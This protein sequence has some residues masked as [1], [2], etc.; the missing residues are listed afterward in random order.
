MVELAPQQNLAAPK[1]T[2]SKRRHCFGLVVVNV[3]TGKSS[4]DSAHKKVKS[5]L[6]SRLDET[7]KEGW[8]SDSSNA[9]DHV[10]N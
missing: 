8:C 3:S 10:G 6:L 5:A 1:G 7:M 4:S 9:Y 2:F